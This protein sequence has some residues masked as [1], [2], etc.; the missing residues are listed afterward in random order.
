MLSDI[1]KIADDLLDWKDA[2]LTN[3]ITDIR[4]GAWPSGQRVALAIRRPRVRVPLWG[5]F[6]ESPDN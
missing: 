6:L 3:D 1:F 5:P 2:F 4:E